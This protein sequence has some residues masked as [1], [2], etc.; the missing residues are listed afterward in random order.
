MGF[1]P[2]G[3]LLALLFPKGRVDI[4]DVESRE[5]IQRFEGGKR[6]CV[7]RTDLSEMSFSTYGSTLQIGKETFRLDKFPS[8]NIQFIPRSP[9]SLDKTWSWVTWKNHRVLY[10][11][12]ERRTSECAI[13]NNSIAM[14]RK[15][16][17]LTILKFNPDINPLKDFQ[18]V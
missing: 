2:N 18:P 16:G 17:S 5:L 14:A 15:S 7:C 8:E 11:P 12:P 10:L 1:Q 9:Y 13:Q 4:W 6:D 3:S